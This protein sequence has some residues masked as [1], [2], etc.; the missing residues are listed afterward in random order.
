MHLSIAV[1]ALVE[2]A[3]CLLA[4]YG[5]AH[6]RFGFDGIPLVERQLVVPAVICACAMVACMT[7]V[8]LYAF[9]QRAGLSGIVMRLLAAALFSGLN[10]RCGPT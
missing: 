4:A 5:A 7:A 2:F 10:H 9:Q 8:G 1:L 6:L 3:I